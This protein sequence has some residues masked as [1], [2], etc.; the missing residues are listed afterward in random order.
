[1]SGI[2]SRVSAALALCV[3]A[4]S[5]AG[6]AATQEPCERYGSDAI[7]TCTAAIADASLTAEERSKAFAYRG[8]ARRRMGEIAPAL[9]DFNEALT[10]DPNNL[11]AV[12]EW[13]ALMEGADPEW[14]VC[15][16]Q[17]APVEKR[18]A[19]CTAIVDRDAASVVLRREALKR[20]SRIY[21]LH[22][23]RADN[24]RALGDLNLVLEISPQDAS[25]LMARAAV[26]RARGQ[27]R[28]AIADFGRAA[29]LRS[30][31]T[32]PLVE[33]GEVYE[34]QGDLENARRDYETALK[35]ERQ[36]NESLAQAKLQQL[37][38]S[39]ATQP[40]LAAAA[41]NTETPAR[42]LAICE[43]APAAI[44]PDARISACNAA[45]AVLTEAAAQ[46][47]F[48]LFLDRAR[49]FAWRG[50]ASYEKGDYDIA[51]ADLETAIR[52]DPNFKFFFFLRGKIHQARD[53]LT[54]AA[55]DFTH[56]AAGNFQPAFA[57]LA[58]VR[59]EQKDYPA[60]TQQ[61]EEALQR[62]ATDVFALLTREKLNMA[63]GQLA[64]ALRDCR[65]ALAIKPELK[66]KRQCLAEKGEAAVAT[67][68]QPPAVME[69]T[70]AIP[71]PRA[72]ALA[73]P[74]PQAAPKAPA[75]EAAAPHQVLAP[76]PPTLPKDWIKDAPA[77][78]QQHPPQTLPK[79]WIKAR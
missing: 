2:T 19:G 53:D 4:A 71:V 58:A 46:K 67:P 36:P 55:A 45:L 79:D 41:G 22:M 30:A 39:D 8:E 13:E 18:L 47:N 7:E 73:P 10:E 15:N 65:A 37:D 25:A 76:L 14:A 57:Q 51:L 63:L 16:A 42:N 12:F 48:V 50:W 66:A 28:S 60:A 77:H 64:D 75:P 21:N 34:E 31:D 70:A 3:L 56:A 24:D 49:A 74:A 20:R 6:Q 44:D 23:G 26:H 35:L 68:V 17:A 32:Q 59:L 5:S 78:Q 11:S 52:T 54:R 29:E 1:M 27:Y 69:T 38:K 9:D 61:I 72:E 62:D 43:S 33:R 40:V